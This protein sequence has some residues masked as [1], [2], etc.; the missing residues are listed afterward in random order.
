MTNAIIN[1][2][3]IPQA[4]TQAVRDLIATTPDKQLFIN[5]EYREPKSDQ[6]LE[7]HDPATGKLIARIANASA[8]DVDAAVA[9]ARTA[10][11]GP[12]AR[13]TPMERAGILNKI[14]DL[15]DANIDELCELEIL[16][17]GKP[18][19][20]ARWAEVP[21][22]ANQFRF[23][24]GQAMNIEGQI[25][26]TSINYQPAGHDVQAWTVRE[27]VGVVA[28]ITP[29]NSPL[30]LTAMKLA[31]ALA[32]GCTIVHK[33]AELTSLTA[34]RL[35]ELMT[36][37]GVPAG[38]MNVITGE[39][40]KTGS[41]LASHTGV[42][43]VA[44]TGSTATG[45]AIVDASKSNLKRI[46]LELGGKSP[47]IVLPDANLDLAIPGIANGIFFNGGQ[48]CVA[49]SRT[50]IHRSIFD[51][52][53]EGI[54]NYG[55]GLRMGHG[56]DRETQ[57]GP[58][59]SPQQAEKIEHYIKTAKNEGATIVTGGERL[60]SNGTFIQPT[61]VTGT[62]RNS[63][64]HCEEVFGPVIVA[65]PY[66]DI[67]DALAWSNDSEFG[68]ASSIW[69][70]D[71]ASAQRLSR[72]IQAGTVWIN[73]H[74]MF[75]PSMPIGGIKQSGYGRDSGKWALDNYLD[76]KTICAVV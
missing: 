7:T 26:T 11:S 32:A 28:A 4:E 64:I 67:N 29:W 24:A 46:T 69:T 23:F 38:V 9:A 16:D 72:Q 34:L 36:Q 51:K 59:V 52:V 61:V 35:A 76:W 70:Q 14:A 6:Y 37:A 58:V 71:F 31:P 25:L 5:G 1:D 27:P 65:E 60:G 50:Y 54:A 48:V 74:S 39:G 43:K 30:V 73:T 45:R 42:N 40:A 10:L 21:A 8:S 63:A 66:D 15:I 12:W 56:L 3:V 33:P 22:A 2:G 13:M 75:D 17:Q 20:V 62:Q 57:M 47:A 18:W 49:N 41:I 68:L 53:V 19:Y 44:F 55:A